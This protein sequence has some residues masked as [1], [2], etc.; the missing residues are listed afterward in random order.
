MKRAGA[1]VLPSQPATVIPARAP[2]LAAMNRLGTRSAGL[3][4]ALAVLVGS[5]LTAAPA[6]AAG[7]AIIKDCQSNGQLTKTYSLA[8]LRHALDVLPASVKE[9]T[10]CSDVIQQA[11]LAARHGHGGRRVDD[12]PEL[13]WLLPADAGDHHP[14]GADPRRGDVR[15]AGDPA[16]AR[17]RAPGAGPGGSGSDTAPT[18]VMPS[19]PGR[20]ATTRPAPASCP[21]L[22]RRRRRPAATPLA[23]PELRLH[24]RTCLLRSRAVVCAAGGGG[25]H[26]PRERIA[27]TFRRALLLLQP[28]PAWRFR[29]SAGAVTYGLGD[30][31]GTFARCA[32]GGAPGVCPAATMG[33]Y[34]AEPSFRALTAPT[35]EH[36]VTEVRLFVAYD[37]IEE[38]NGSPTSPGCTLSR[39][40]QQP[41]TD[42][43]GRPHPRAESWDDLDA[44]LVAAHDD[45]LTPVVSIAGYASPNAIPSWDQPMPDP[46]TVAGWWEYYCGVQGALNAASKLPVVDRPH[47]WEAVNEPDGFAVDNGNPDSTDESCA[48]TPDSQLAGAAKAACDYLIASPRDPPVRRSRDDTVIAG[49]FTH[50]SPRL[51]E[52]VC[53]AAGGAGAGRRVPEHL[54]GA[55]LRRRD[56]LLRGAGRDSP[57]AVRPG[58]GD[59]F[60][61]C[62]PRSVG[63]RGG[64]AADR[65]HRGG[66]LSRRR[67]GCRGHAGRVRQRPG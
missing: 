55:R 57:A 11:I 36:Q 45:G 60:G 64:H 50:P 15:R 43:A 2:K 5:A 63:D 56:Q 4:C 52:T 17:A 46:T 24:L 53:G 41:W 62:G 13:R 7:N 19:P 23:S 42:G 39:V 29:P 20:P 48:V 6:L 51:P 54:V 8:Q 30:A 32:P 44:G 49:V 9:Y 28:A 14:G 26:N 31:P 25:L 66:R 21:R 12:R 16:P 27:R 65:S 38:Y 40:A 59:R 1:L 37:A 58:S 67:R 34:Y 18:R 61:R 47:I 3:L 22:S 33:G 10:N 35:S